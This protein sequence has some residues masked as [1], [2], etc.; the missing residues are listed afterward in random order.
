MNGRERA[1]KIYRILVYLLV[2]TIS[3]CAIAYAVG[4]IAGIILSSIFMGVIP[5]VFIF[6]YLL[7]DQRDY[8]Y[9][10]DRKGNI[11]LGILS[12]ILSFGTLVF[13]IYYLD[14][15]GDLLTGLAYIFN[16]SGWVSLAITYFI[17]IFIKN[18]KYKYI[19]HHDVIHAEVVKVER[20]NNRYSNRRGSNSTMYQV[21]LQEQFGDRKFSA[22]FNFDPSK[23]MKADSIH[24][25]DVYLHPSNPDKY[26]VEKRKVV[27]LFSKK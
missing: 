25:L 16:A 26:Y 5:T 2:L 17:F 12:I 6:F 3:L 11:Y 1:S 8:L 10:K 22:Y 7:K 15:T 19:E 9:G 20:I 21:T 23:P 14:Y 24:T 18:N 4:G 13:A 27:R